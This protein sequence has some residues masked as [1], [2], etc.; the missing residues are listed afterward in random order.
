M[1]RQEAKRATV[2]RCRKLGWQCDDDNQGDALALWSF[3]C[4]QIDPTQALMV[5][6]LFNRSPADHAAMS[7]V[8]QIAE[9]VTLYLGDCR[10]IL[11]ALPKVDAVVTDPPYGI[12]ARWGGGGG[13]WSVRH[14]N[15]I[16][17]DSETFNPHPFLDFPDVILWSGII[18]RTSFPLRL[19]G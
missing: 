10:E 1:R 2:E 12:N 16:V 9:G 6:P 17:G 4:A 8:E 7:R 18:L 3:A 13:I 14:G 11:P 15:G 5:S 19:A